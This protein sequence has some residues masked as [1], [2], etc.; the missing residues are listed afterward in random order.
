METMR[1]LKSWEGLGKGVIIV[2]GPG[3]AGRLVSS[4]IAEIV[5][6]AP[7]GETAPP[8]EIQVPVDIDGEEPLATEQ[9][10]SK[11]KGRK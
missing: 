8:E 2:C 7:A 1:L 5:G 4:G 9:V 3:R 10:V 6:A 11:P